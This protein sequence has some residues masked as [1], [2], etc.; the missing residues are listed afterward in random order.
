MHLNC[1]LVYPPWIRWH[2]LCCAPR[3]PMC[4]Q[5]LR[6]EVLEK[7]KEI[8]WETLM[9]MAGSF[10]NRIWVSPPESSGS[11][12]SSVTVCW[13]HD[14]VPHSWIFHDYLTDCLVLKIVPTPWNEFQSVPVSFRSL[15]LNCVSSSAKSTALI[16]T[17]NFPLKRNARPYISNSLQPFHEYW[18]NTLT[19]LYSILCVGQNLYLFRVTA[20]VKSCKQ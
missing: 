7:K 19:E 9:E 1:F 13:E 17:V 18:G 10:R 8:A 4:K 20:V 14:N 11:G 6:W 5:E 16:K 2:V 15:F 12:Y 3:H